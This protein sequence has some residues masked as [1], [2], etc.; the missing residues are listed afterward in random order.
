MIYIHLKCISLEGK[1][2]FPNPRW[3]QPFVKHLGLKLIW[4]LSYRHILLTAEIRC[5]TTWTK[6]LKITFS[7]VLQHQLCCVSQF[8]IKTWKLIS[9]AVP[10]WHTVSTV[11]SKLIEFVNGKEKSYFSRGFDDE[12][13]IGLKSLAFLHLEWR[14]CA[15]L[16]RIRCLS[17]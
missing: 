3:L 9:I 12:G 2:C 13:R 15:K 11:T 17:S 4:S 8:V 7:F 14:K 1:L 6:W 5:M 10:G 16:I